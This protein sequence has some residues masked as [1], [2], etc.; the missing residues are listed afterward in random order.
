[1]WRASSLLVLL[2]L[3]SVLTLGTTAA[4]GHAALVGS[5]PA[6]G[7]LLPDAPSRFVLTFNEPVSPLVSTPTARCFLTRRRASSS[8]STS[9]FRRW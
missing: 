5:D 8:R 1:M 7:A 4:L 6:D 9:R 2:A 3:C